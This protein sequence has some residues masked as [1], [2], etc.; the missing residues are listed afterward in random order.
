MSS[1]SDRLSDLAQHEEAEQLGAHAQAAREA[2][3]PMPETSPRV[4]VHGEVVTWSGERFRV[5][6]LT[7][8]GYERSHLIRLESLDSGRVE[9]VE[10]NDIERE[11][12]GVY[13]RV[14]E[15]GPP[16]HFH[17]APGM[18]MDCNIVGNRVKITITAD[19]LSGLT[20]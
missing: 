20:L 1:P 3:P 9:Y 2:M 8:S 19:P 6:G 16:L 5:T 12:A 4:F 14:T 15:A 7:P 17:V 11:G 18:R 10:A 13:P